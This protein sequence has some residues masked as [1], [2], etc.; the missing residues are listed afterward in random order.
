MGTMRLAMT[1][2]GLLLAVTI[3]A[4]QP[5]AQSGPQTAPPRATETYA[6]AAIDADG[7]LRIVTTARKVVVVPRGGAPESAASSGRQTTFATPVLSDDRSAVA[8]P[9][10]FKNC[11]T[12]YDIPLQL[13][14]YS[15]GRTH[16]FEGGLAI[17]DWHF[18]DGGRRVVFSQQTVHFACS[19]RWELRDVASER[20]LAAAD[21]AEPCGENPNPAP[22]K[23]PEWVTGTTS[24]FR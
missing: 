18:A 20:L 2:A 19:V 3:T 12:S 11:C 7:N 9:A 16:R 5:A 6:S 24:G 13:V 4:P 10:L 22:V 23:A 1:M 17:F 21:V 14:V 15:Q 8:A